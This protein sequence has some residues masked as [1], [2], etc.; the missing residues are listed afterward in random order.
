MEVPWDDA[1]RFG[2]MVTDD[3]DAS[4]L[5]SV[6]YIWGCRVSIQS[7]LWEASSS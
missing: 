3:E 6:K 1:S 4:E 2:L 7:T 5:C